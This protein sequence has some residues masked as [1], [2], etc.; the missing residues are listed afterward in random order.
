MDDTILNLE[1]AID[2]LS[3]SEKTMIK[4]LREEHIPARK[5]GR[6]WRFSKAA[7]TEWLATGDSIQYSNV[8]A[9][10]SFSKD[11]KGS[12]GEM[13]Q[14]VRTETQRLQDAPTINRILEMDDA[15]A[16]PPEATM[17]ITYKQMHD[18]EKLR[19]ELFWPQREE[20]TR[21]L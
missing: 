16:V 13:L 21:Q 2:F 19:F 11:V 6:E 12:F 10:Y 5:I 18:T 20:F 7:L 17:R 8:T 15:I 9:V 1:G 4:L 14:T 3:V